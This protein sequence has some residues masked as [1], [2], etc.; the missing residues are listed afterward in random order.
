M[1]FD[2]SK[3]ADATLVAAAELRSQFTALKANSDLVARKTS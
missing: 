3:P 1:A 2:P